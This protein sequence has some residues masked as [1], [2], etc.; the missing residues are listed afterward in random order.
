M[1]E[2]LKIN[3][4]E[5]EEANRDLNIYRC[6][7]CN[8]SE[9][10]FLLCDDCFKNYISKFEDNINNFLNTEKSIIKKIDLILT[11]N[12]EKSKKLNHKIYLDKYKQILESRIQQ[13]EIKIKK[14][15]EEA[16]KYENLVINQKDKNNGLEHF[17]K[18]ND[19][20]GN[21]NNK[22]KNISFNNSLNNSI[23][24]NNDVYR[25]E[26]SKTKNEI[27]DINS[28]IKTYKKKYIYDLFQDLFIKKKTIIKISD[29]FN[30]EQQQNNNLNFSIILTPNKNN[31]TDMNQDDS[32]SDIIKLNLLRENDVLLKRLNSF[33]KT[34]VSFLEKA[35]NKF[36]IKMP[37]KINHFKVEYKNGFEYNIEINKNQLNNQSE[38][39]HVVKGYHLLSINYIYLM[40]NI[41]GDSIKLNDWFDISFFLSEQ[42]DDIGSI[43]TIIE[44][45]KNEEKEKEY[46]GFIVI[47]D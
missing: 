17:L 25:S 20:G 27:F 2:N 39:G 22:D 43:K 31:N 19:F 37:F 34:M 18:D 47:D 45:A 40:Q 6:N 38:I 1:E 16:S 46:N 28:K 4:R 26:I 3:A 10:E 7:I 5:E 33:F 9:E 32:S 29:F 44:D 35:F 14:Y 23:N 13:E 15:K 24:D 21:I 30:D 8:N 42:N 12:N 36:K 41:F 11:F